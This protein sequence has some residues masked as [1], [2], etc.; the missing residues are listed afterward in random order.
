SQVKGAASIAGDVAASGS[1]AQVSPQ[2]PA[3]TDP[4]VPIEAEHL[5]PGDEK[6]FR[7]ILVDTIDTMV[8]E[9]ASVRGAPA[10]N[11]N[12][13]GPLAEGVP[14]APSSSSHI[15]AATMIDPQTLSYTYT[16]HLVTSSLVELQAAPE[17]AEASESVGKHPHTQTPSP[18][19]SSV[20]WHTPAGVSD[21][22]PLVKT[23]TETLN[24]AVE[25]GE[26]EALT[27]AQGNPSDGEYVTGAGIGTCKDVSHEAKHDV[28]AVQSD[29]AVLS[30]RAEG[31]ESALHGATVDL[32]VHTDVTQ[33]V[34]GSTPGQMKQVMDASTPGHMVD[35][36]GSVD[37][38]TPH[39]TPATDDTGVDV[40]MPDRGMER[41]V[42]LGHMAS[43]EGV[44][45]G[46]AERQGVLRTG[47]PT[48][49]ISSG[50]EEG[51]CGG[52][53]TTPVDETRPDTDNT[54]VR[55]RSRD[56][57]DMPPRWDTQEDVHIS[58][59]GDTRDM[60]P[61]TSISNAQNVPHSESIGGEI[62]MSHTEPTTNSNADETRED[63]GTGEEAQPTTTTTT[64]TTPLLD[65][66]HGYGHGS[67]AVDESLLSPLTNSTYNHKHEQKSV[68]A[69]GEPQ[70]HGSQ[71]PQT[72][73]KHV[74]DQRKQHEQTSVAADGA[75]QSQA[76]TEQKNT[77]RR[78]RRYR[79][80]MVDRYGVVSGAARV[81]RDT[82]RETDH[83]T[84]ANRVL[85]ANQILLSYK[86]V[87]DRYVAFNSNKLPAYP[88]NQ[89]N[90]ATAIATA[91]H[92]SGVEALLNAN[93][94][95]L[96]SSNALDVLTHV[97]SARGLTDTLDGKETV[98][99]RSVM[100]KQ[101]I[102]QQFGIDH[103]DALPLRPQEFDIYLSRVTSGIGFKE[104]LQVV[105]NAS[106]TMATDTLA[107]AFTLVARFGYIGT[108]KHNSLDNALHEATMRIHFDG[109]V[110]LHHAAEIIHAS[111]YIFG[112][113]HCAPLRAIAHHQYDLD[114]PSALFDQ[115]L[116]TLTRLVNV[117]G[118]PEFTSHPTKRTVNASPMRLIA[119]RRLR[120][121]RE[122]AEGD[123]AESVGNWDEQN[124][125]QI[126]ELPH[127]DVEWEEYTDTKGQRGR[128]KRSQEAAGK[129]Q[130]GGDRVVLSDSS[131]HGD[132]ANEPQRVSDWALY[133]EAAENEKTRS[134]RVKPVKHP[135]K[136]YDPDRYEN[137]GRVRRLPIT[138]SK[139]RHRCPK[140][141]RYGPVHG[142][143]GAEV[144]AVGGIDTHLQHENGD[145]PSEGTGL[146]RDDTHTRISQ[147]TSSAMRRDRLA[148]RT[149]SCEC[150]YDYDYDYVQP[151]NLLRTRQALTW[152][153]HESLVGLIDRLETSE[154]T[155][156][157]EW[158]VLDALHSVSHVL[159]SLPFYQGNDK[160]FARAALHHCANLMTLASPGSL[161]LFLRDEADLIIARFCGMLDTVGPNDNVEEMVATMKT[162]IRNLDRALPSSEHYLKV[163]RLRSI[164]STLDSTMTRHMQLD[165]DTDNSGTLELLLEMEYCSEKVRHALSAQ[166][167]QEN[168]WEL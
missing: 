134:S 142:A 124:Q 57:P 22:R 76:Q 31:Q 140:R 17:A 132:T 149:G 60:V 125:G 91:H 3:T 62:G 119:R 30:G 156:S 38:T 1:H 16:T 53:K 83:N 14:T 117:Y 6:D 92:I 144:G 145:S 79:T 35:S 26:A 27:R 72:S 7:R 24:G 65:S 42:G 150:G 15:T 107:R 86:G 166:L 81:R 63:L 129:D 84:V 133:M 127:A 158:E 90:F 55:D 36:E 73:N 69:N 161:E 100:T 10:A 162:L 9:T 95:Y 85:S 115:N 160:Y 2:E 154:P 21:E 102:N 48:D 68:A 121:R 104:L 89:H 122:Q 23:A 101:G 139:P 136:M 25:V 8:A 77:G 108:G 13:A 78:R 47:V 99:A 167:M 49:S 94:R 34:D 87:S 88:W 110:L 96:T 152:A 41:R 109:D 50:D 164:E 54:S 58:N 138:H 159:E 82:V 146:A 103:F 105:F 28:G 67:V 40:V 116:S 33:V 113:A 29:T 11:P 43:A 71:I 153:V 112:R 155:P 118:G 165:I 80:S 141:D 37:S 44:E 70:A 148:R 151:T 135:L 120:R 56:G 163:N 128:R 51:D 93:W 168:F 32:R 98:R 114:S 123:W 19:N 39:T 111:H 66:A 45:R 74:H 18:A 20:I 64:T 126:S 106:S 4:G 52:A 137:C 5:P 75:S 143:P 131:A 59:I 46:Q 130:V 97:A 147:G 157:D 61:S 12:T